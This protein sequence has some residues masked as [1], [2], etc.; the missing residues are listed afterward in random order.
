MT[1]LIALVVDPVIQARAQAELDMV[2]GRNRLPDFS[3]RENLPYIQCIISETF[4]YV[5]FP[6]NIR[7][8]A[9]VTFFSFPS[10]GELQLPWVGAARSFSQQKI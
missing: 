9:V 8:A 4:R 1:A 5:E 2:I 7:G 10:D 3:D 6:S